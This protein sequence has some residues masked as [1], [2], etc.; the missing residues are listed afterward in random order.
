[1][2]YNNNNVK[3]YTTYCNRINMKKVKDSDTK[4]KNLL[5]SK[6]VEER[7]SVIKKHKELAKEVVNDDNWKVRYTAISDNYALPVQ[8]IERFAR[9]EDKRVSNKAKYMLDIL[10]KY[11][12]RE[13]FKD[14]IS[15]K[16]LI[17]G[18]CNAKCFFCYGNG[19]SCKN[20]KEFQI[21]FLEN[22]LYSLERIILEIGDKQEISLD[23]TGGEPTLDSNFLIQVLGKLRTFYLLKRIKKVTLT[24]NG[25]KLKEVIPSLKGVVDYVNISIHHYDKSKREKIFGAKTFTNDEYKE[26]VLKLIDNDIVP[27]AVA[28]IYEEIENFAKFRDNMIS[29]SEDIGFSGI[30]FRKNVYWKDENS[31]RKYKNITIKNCNFKYIQGQDTT[32][33]T[34]CKLKTKTGFLVYFISGVEDTTKVSLGAEFVIND[35]GIGYVDFDKKQKISEYKLPV[36]LVFDKK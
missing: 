35:D 30:R 25:F 7:I 34:W 8:V 18:G 29:W 6:S 9:D 22:F 13:E 23:I 27:T 17:P 20:K 36:G 11:I 2:K 5:K 16:L 28:I 21:Q 32:N 1:M 4:V 10:S 31:F 33:L 14:T 15:I 24:S 12:Y 26:I 19:Y 3:D